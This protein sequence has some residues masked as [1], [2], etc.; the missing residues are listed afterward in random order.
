LE[1]YRQSQ[2]GLVFEAQRYG[3]FGTS[4]T[5]ELQRAM[6]A[7]EGAQ[8]CIATASGLS[9]IVSVLATYGG[10]GRH[11]LVSDGVY[12][13]TRTFCERELKALG[14]QVEYFGHDADVGALIRPST[15]L[16]F[17]ETPSSITMEVLDV[18]RIC[19]AARARGVPVAA[20]STWGTPMF[21]KPHALGVNLSIHSATKYINGHSDV[22][23][24]LITGS[25]QDTEAVRSYCERSGSHAAADACW[26]ALRGLRTLAVRLQRHQDSALV[27]AQWLAA[28]AEVSRVMFPALPS[29][30]GHALWRKQFSGAA[31][32][33]SFEFKSCSDA[34]L[35]RFI[36]ALRLFGLGVSWGGFESLALPVSAHR[37]C[38]LQ[39]P[40]GPLVR[41]HIGLE[42]VDDL[43]ADLAQAFEQ[44]R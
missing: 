37:S 8:S 30:P 44:L 7:L 35:H 14:T 42:D 3:R 18:A 5:F 39:P 16:I 1:E 10:P 4:T 36:D 11:I 38:A 24:G 2:T 13:P 22:M 12:G 15:S 28:R 40:A 31:G 34:A 6:A 23:L 25:Y 27:V 43:C 21:F 33:F 20:D 17:I 29:D 19:D 32:P 41:L 9:A 26:L